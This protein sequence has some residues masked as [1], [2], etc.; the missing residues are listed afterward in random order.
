MKKMC[1]FKIIVGNIL[2]LITNNLKILKQFM[3]IICRILICNFT[4]LT[5]FNNMIFKFKELKRLKINA[6]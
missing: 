3:L 6:I 4:L 2:L 5:R 1:L